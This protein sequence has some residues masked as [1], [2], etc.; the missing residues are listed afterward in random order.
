[1]NLN[2]E[3]GCRLLQWYAENARDLP[4]RSTDDPY[5][6]WISE[7]I[8]QQTRVEQGR[9]HYL[10]FIEKFPTAESLANADTDEVLLSW[11]GL[12]YYS[13]AM[14]LHTAAK[15][16][17]NDFGG[18]F[19]DNFNEILKLKGVGRYTAAAIASIA[20]GEDIPAVDGNFYRVLSRFFADDFDISRSAAHGYF[21]ELA[22]MLMPP[23]RAGDFNQAVM[24]L[25]SGICRPRKPLCRECPLEEGCAAA[26]TGTAELYPKKTKKVRKTELAL[27]Y[28]F[29]EWR[30]SFLIRRRGTDFIW[31]NL[32][33]FPAEVPESFQKYS[34]SS[35]LIHHQLTHR[36]LRITIN[37]YKIPDEHLFRRYAAQGGFLI[38]D[39]EGSARKSF[40]QPLQRF[41]GEIFS[42]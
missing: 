10:N 20:F 25:G 11:K 16:L 6:I 3:A 35:F 42:S 14:N 15:Q 13:R 39:L 7:I 8:L 9:Q 26:G 2:L 1:M 23:G 18:N 31:K 38:T 12:G 32:Y 5:K 37:H 27:G 30:G 33:E 19:P 21:S 40:P 41:I 4:W 29:V 17:V 36:S 34:E 28:A 22:K 24:D